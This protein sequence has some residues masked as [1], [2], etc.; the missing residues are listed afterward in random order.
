MSDIRVVQVPR[1]LMAE[2]WPHLAPSMMRGMKRIGMTIEQMNHEIVT[3]QSQAWAIMD[4]KTV[5]ASF[6]T[7]LHLDGYA[8]VFALG[9]AGLR[10][11]SGALEAEMMR[12][13]SEN[14]LERVRFAGRRA[15]SRV[16]PAWT[17]IDRHPSGDVIFER[18]ST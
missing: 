9:G 6:L 12:F 10:R 18:A 7:S 13:A 16:L 4:G 2:M 17:V 5:L 14:Q 8:S 3:G 11:W 1:I 15:W